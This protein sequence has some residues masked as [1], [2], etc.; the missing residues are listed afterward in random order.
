MGISSYIKTILLPIPEASHSFLKVFV[1]L[2]KTSN[3]V[4]NK[5]FY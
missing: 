3:G 5:L 4:Q 1:K 2:D